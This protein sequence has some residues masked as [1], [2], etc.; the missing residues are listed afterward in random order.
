MKNISLLIFIFIPFFTFG[1]VE[2]ESYKEV[3]A[4]FEALYNADKY[5]NIFNL[6]SPEMKAA[7]PIEKTINFL[8]GLKSQAGKIK[9]CE[10][11]KYEKGVYASYKSK[12]E[13]A[14]LSVHIAL[15]KNSNIRLEI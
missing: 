13:R 11:I 12:F 1:Q 4:K 14:L 8:K 7:L 2:K 10:F 15:D 3:S 9:S 5:Q 6:F